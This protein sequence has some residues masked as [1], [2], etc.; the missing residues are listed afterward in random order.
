MGK[1]GGI[2]EHGLTVTA[3]HSTLGFRVYSLGFIVWGL[4]FGV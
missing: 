3:W 1:N 2:R 4:G